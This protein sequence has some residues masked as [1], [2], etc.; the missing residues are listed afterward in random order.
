ME[1]LIEKIMKVDY[2][3]INAEQ[4]NTSAI[5][6]FVDKMKDI[7][8]IKWSLR[9]VRR[10]LRRANEFLGY[11]P[12]DEELSNEIKPITS[13]DIALS[14]ILSGHT[15]DEERKNDMIDQTVRIFSGSIE[16][17]NN[18]AQGRTHFKQTYQGRYLVS[19]H[20]ALKIENEAKFPQ[21]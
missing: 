13:T 19:G 7:L 21:P 1:G 4:L 12:N 6:E 14:F 16:D 15:L 8:H 2:Q 18:L 9:D 17:A 5:R 20:I 11:R 10:F 3:N